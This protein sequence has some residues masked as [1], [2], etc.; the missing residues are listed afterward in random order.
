MEAGGRLSGL[1][2][3]PLDGRFPRA[4]LHGSCRAQFNRCRRGQGGSRSP[5]RP[6]SVLPDHTRSRGRC[7]APRRTGGARCGRHV[8]RR[9]SGSSRLGSGPGARQIW[10]AGAD[11]REP[12][13]ADPDETATARARP[14]RPRD[15]RAHGRTCGAVHRHR[16]EERPPR[17]SFTG[18]RNPC[19]ER[20]RRPPRR[21]P[22]GPGCRSRARMSDD[23]ITRVDD[24]I[25]WGLSSWPSPRAPGP[26]S[27]EFAIRRRGR[28]ADIVGDPDPGAGVRR[29]VEVET[30]AEPVHER[31][32]PKQLDP[33]AAPALRGR[34][35][36]GHLPPETRRAGGRSRDGLDGPRAHLVD[37]DLLA[38]AA[39]VRTGRLPDDLRTLATGG[40]E[41]IA[42]LGRSGP[43]HAARLAMDGRWTV[44][45]EATE[46]GA[47]VTVRSEGPATWHGSTG[48]GPPV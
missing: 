42:A 16:P 30:G 35:P 47:V 1:R 46:D 21:R 26:S 13:C 27:S 43:A 36:R 37:M 4:R 40:A 44:L 23:E 39:T 48:A 18:G 2:G 32:Q 15:R 17:R 10:S 14:G 31:R 25:P 3:A 7:G 24:L 45:G 33:R 34:R 12:P 22:D 6:S 20:D 11:H 28:Q 29:A 19:P 9:T 5:T 38:T 8:S 41:T